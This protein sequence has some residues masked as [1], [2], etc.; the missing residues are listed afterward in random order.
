MTKRHRDAVTS[1]N[2]GKLDPEDAQPYD[3]VD[4][5]PQGAWQKFERGEIPLFEFYEAFSRELSDTVQGNLW[6]KAYCK[7]KGL[8][9]R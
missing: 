1:G 9:E 6:Y 8:S 4:R 2:P 3:S 7:R 5:G